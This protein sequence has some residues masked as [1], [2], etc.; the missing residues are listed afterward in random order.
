MYSSFNF[1]FFIF[2]FFNYSQ[3]V[4]ADS[5]GLLLLYSSISTS[6]H[7]TFLLRQYRSN[8]P[9]PINLSEC[10]HCQRRVKCYTLVADLNWSISPN[11]FMNSAAFLANLGLVNISSQHIRPNAT[12]LLPSS[13]ILFLFRVYRRH[14]ISKYF[15]NCSPRLKALFGESKPGTLSAGIFPS[16]F[17][18][19]LFG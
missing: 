11:G 12:F 13:N 3:P 14:S 7:C 9:S 4:E 19:F 18:R 10:T 15:A 5:R 17:F 6:V 8:G 2:Y 1:Y 16:R